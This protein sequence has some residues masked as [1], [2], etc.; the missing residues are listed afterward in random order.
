[1]PI[2]N[3]DAIS[4]SE[5]SKFRQVKIFPATFPEPEKGMVYDFAKLGLSDQAMRSVEHLRGPGTLYSFDDKLK[6][7][8]EGVLIRLP[9]KEQSSLQKHA[10]VTHIYETTVGAVVEKQGEYFRSRLESTADRAIANED[11]VVVYE[12]HEVLTFKGSRVTYTGDE[13][14]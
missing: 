6:V 12:L 3:R 10:E 9:E 2:Q 14:D 4:E 1:M 7:L 5:F 13:W 8:T 11:R